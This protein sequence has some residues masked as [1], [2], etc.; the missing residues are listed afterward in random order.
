MK[1]IF[2]LLMIVSILLISCGSDKDIYFV[3]EKTAETKIY[4]FKQYGLFDKDE[5]KNDKI[6]Y[7]IIVGN[8][9]WAILLCETLFVPFIIIGWY[10]YEPIGATVKVNDAPKGTIKDFK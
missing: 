6:E 7:K 3:N 2:S 4:T 9:V 5:I 1:K 8:V 10:L